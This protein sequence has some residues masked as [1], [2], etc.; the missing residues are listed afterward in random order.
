MKLKYLQ[1]VATLKL[2]EENCIGCG[3]CAEVCPH[4]V[5]QINDH[6]ASILDLNSCMECGACSRNCPVHAIQVTPGTG[7]VYAVLKSYI[8]KLTGKPDTGVC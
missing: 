1:N 8:N 4:G 3:R 5:F 7:C 6:K 2:N